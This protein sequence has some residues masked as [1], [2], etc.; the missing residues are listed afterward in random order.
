MVRRVTDS[1]IEAQFW[2]QAENE[3]VMLP[4]NEIA[5]FKVLRQVDKVTHG[6]YSLV[7]LG[8]NDEHPVTEI[9]ALRAQVRFMRANPRGACACGEQ[10]A[11]AAG[12]QGVGSAAEL[13]RD[14]R[15]CLSNCSYSSGCGWWH[16]MG[17]C[18]LQ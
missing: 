9:E 18:L 5:S 11:G 17:H 13:T 6:E 2:V 10:T 14:A 12:S 3:W 15:G 7:E 1:H 4:L 8:L 16:C